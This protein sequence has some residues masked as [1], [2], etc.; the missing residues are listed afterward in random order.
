[1][2]QSQPEAESTEEFN[3]AG[4][5]DILNCSLTDCNIGLPV[6]PSQFQYLM[7]SNY[8]ILATI[9]TGEQAETFISDYSSN[10][11]S[12]W[13]VLRTFAK[14]PATLVYKRAWR[15]QYNVQQRRKAVRDVNKIKVSKNFQCPGYICVSVYSDKYIKKG[16]TAWESGNLID[17]DIRSYCKDY[18]C[19]IKLNL[20]HNNS[21][22]SKDVLRH[23]TLG[24][25]V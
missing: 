1:M 14:L 2:S 6:F 4:R 18:P 12:E 5:E 8:E 22:N 21:L 10:S 25:T 20:D 13:R 7:V 9:R 16:M 24:N 17:D 11:G 23:R 15:C 3:D 19:S